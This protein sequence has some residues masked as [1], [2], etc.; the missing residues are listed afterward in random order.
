MGLLGVLR[1]G[2]VAARNGGQIGLAEILLDGVAGGGDGLRRHVHA[3]GSHIGDEAH[4]LAA[5]VHALIEALGD[6]H[7]PGGG[8]AELARGLLLQRRGAEGRVGVALGGLRLDRVHLEGLALHRLLDG[9]RGGFVRNVVVAQLL[10]RDG[11]ERGLELLALGRH[12]GA[13]QRP[14]FARPESL[15]LEFAVTDDAQCH[16]LHAARR[17]RTRQL[18]PQHGR[19]GEP[20]EIVQRAPGEIGIHQRAIHVARVLH[21]LQHGG[22][23][24]GI[25]HHALHGLALQRA[26]PPQHFQHVPGDGLA[27]AVRVGGENQ[28]VVRFEGGGNVG[29]PLGGLAVHLPVHLEV[30][31]GAHRTIFGGQVADMA[32]GSEDFEILAQILVDGLGLGRRF[33]N[34]NGHQVVLNGFRGVI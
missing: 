28:P 32:V 30:G 8:E 21:G 25:E 26:L 2:R 19:E 6:L 4:R 13:V 7:G 10:A 18:P 27:F 11:V 33:Y 24:D 14:V 1:L 20:N 17:T 22:F 16:R 5:D 23:G 9:P 15:D 12:E 29:E 31:V 3:V 34:D